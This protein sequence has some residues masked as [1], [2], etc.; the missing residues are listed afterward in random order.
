MIWMVHEVSGSTS[1]FKIT[2]I[3]QSSHKITCLNLEFLVHV[4]RK[5]TLHTLKPLSKDT[6]A[7]LH[8]PSS[9]LLRMLLSTFL[10]TKLI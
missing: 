8:L 2:L 1:F 7:C 5:N 9:V 6:L 10:S 3:N 4:L